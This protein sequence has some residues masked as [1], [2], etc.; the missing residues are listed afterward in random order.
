MK[1]RTIFLFHKI[2][3][4]KTIKM[5][6]AVIIAISILSSCR[7]D[8]I[9]TDLETIPPI[10]EVN[11]EATFNGFVSD[12]NGEPILGASVK[13]LNQMAET[14]ELGFFEIKGL[15]NEEFA[16]LAV[17]KYGYFS[18][19]KTL[20]PSKTAK[21]RTRIQLVERT[22]SGS[23]SAAS[24]ATISIDGASKVSFQANS[25]V[26]ES[27][28]IYNGT[29]HV[30]AFF[31][32]PTGDNVEQIMPGNLMG[33][34]TE[35][36]LNILQSFGM[37]NV[38]LEGQNRQK[39]NI[40]KAATLEVAVPTALSMDAPSEI[41]LSYFNETSGLWVEEGSA[42]L[43]N[44]KYIG[45]VNH[46]SLWNC[47]MSFDFT[48]VNGRILD[49]RGLPFLRVRMTDLSTGSSF[50]TWT[51]GDGFFSGAVP[52]DVDILLE[53]LGVCGEEVLFS[54]DIGPFSTMTANLGTFNIS[55]TSNL[56]LISGTLVDCNQMPI[57]EGQVYFHFP[58]QFY[59][60]QVL[61]DASGNFSALLPACEGDDIDVKAANTLNGLISQ[62]S[63]IT[64]TGDN[65]DMGAIEVCTDVS[66]M[67]GSVVFNF[68]GEQ[69]V[70]DNCTLVIS[71]FD[72]AAVNAKQYFFRYY[73]VLPAS[74]DTLVYSMIVEDSNGDLNNPD[75]E[76]IVIEFAIPSSA[77][78]E[79]YYSYAPIYHEDVAS[80]NVLQAA[81]NS[82][83]IMQLS[84]ENI[85]VGIGL[86]DPNGENTYESFEGSS[87]VITAVLQ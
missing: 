56:A 31:I 33:I 68:G 8:S 70:F 22:S 53:V 63:T 50:I 43:E 10:P 5:L 39:L 23:F 18:Q 85:T 83:D 69:K 82:G 74:N 30:Y 2:I 57:T 11:I 78:N 81:D 34:N 44:G 61:T 73:E 84:L 66:P 55:N 45:T 36:E 14:N 32:D 17:E 48:F 80:I 12:V 25:I 49:D 59:I 79:L 41:P 26:D 75:W 60:E 1:V 28:N 7:K 13:I 21:N 72:S 29:V 67:L 71:E 51:Y 58:H 3:V 52:R 54:T 6:F 62:S 47:D 46:F 37:L 64:M 16:V 38:E 76:P 9:T 19:Y 24:G 20:I 86:N 42:M 35:N 15:V 27:G 40:N 77:D 87:M 65:I 4:M